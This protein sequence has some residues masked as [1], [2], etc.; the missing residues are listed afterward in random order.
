MALSAAQM[1]AWEFDPA[2]GNLIISDNAADLFG[3]LP[4]S[5]LDHSNQGFALVHPDDAQRHRAVVMKAVDECGSYLSQFRII[6]PD[7][8]AIIWME[9]RG[10]GVG[11]GPGK[12]TR[13]V[14][15]VMDITSRTNA[16]LR[17]RQLQE[18]LEIAIDA[19]ELGTFHC[20]M[21]LG[22]IVWND[23]CKEHFWLEPDAEID[24]DLFYSI[25][26]PDDRER[27]RA[28]VE[29]C[30]SKGKVYDVEYRTVS[31]HRVVRWL[32]ATG[33]TYYDSDQN[34]IRFDGTT[35][36]ITTRKFNERQDQ[37]VFSLDEAIR[38]LS[39]A[40]T[41]TAT[42]ARML[43][44]NLAVDRCAYAEVLADQN[45][46]DV[47]GDFN[48]G[49]PSIVGRYT[50]D[51]LGA[52][53][54]RLMRANLP[55]IVHDID[56]HQPPLEDLSAYRQTQIQ[57]VVCIPLH[58][59]GKLVAAM[60]VHQKTPRNWTP[61]DV[62]LVELV[63][64]RCWESIE[65]ARFA[66]SLHDS[67]AKFR[68]LAN[69]IPQLAWMA[70]PDG[71]IFWYNERWYEYT[72]TTLEQ[73]QGWG[74]EDVHDPVELKRVSV[75]WKA[76]LAGGQP[77]EDEFPLRRH[78]GEFRWHLSRALPLRD[79]EGRI[80][81][82]FGTNT[83]ITDQRRLAEERG[84]LLENE[85]AAR[86]EAEHVGRMKDEFLATLSHELRTPLN[87]ILGYATLM[88]MAKM[89]ETEIQNAIATIERNA[90]L[91]AQLIEDLLDMNRIISGKVRLEIQSVNLA[92]IV[93][94]SVDTVRPSAEAR[95]IRLQ[96][97][98]DP[99]AGPIR[100]DPGR[101][102]QVVWNLLTNAI[103]FTPKGGKVQVV[104]ERVNSHI[105]IT[106]SDSGQG[107]SAEFLPY[108]FD[109]FRQADASTSRRHGGL[110]LGLSIV[111][112]LVEL[113]GGSVQA[114]SPGEGLGSTFIVSLPVTVVHQPLDPVARQH[115]TTPRFKPYECNV[116]LSG[117][118]VLVVDDEP[119]ATALVER[120]LTECKALVTKAGSSREAILILL[121]QE[122]DVL[123][124]D[125]G[126]PVE[127][128]Y[129]LIQKVRELTNKNKDI[130]AVALTAFARSED[131]QR[132]ALVGFQT[133]LAKPVEAAE[134]VAVV[135]N[136]S[137]RHP[138]GK[139]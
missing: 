102:Q 129:L 88:R 59:H 51:Q 57:A 18:Q 136:L 63:A 100:G 34:P 2:T 64:N 97:I 11:S 8:G 61:R 15:V 68:Q 55:Y 77:W 19:S 116:D 103:K 53:A 95:E 13:L 126:M 48:C 90:R 139:T 132:A 123:I 99:V 124:S 86:A 67:E 5:T 137:K 47:T 29:A 121:Q 91:Q 14:G 58:K 66:R 52:E 65:R 21:P 89:S 131:R 82:W 93:E 27:V 125:I 135:A 83:D 130:A 96:K 32:R 7:N 81:L 54:L 112:H 33:R 39:D 28:A 10:H 70:N 109:R 85:R 49:V 60:A 118:R 22:R 72:G 84:L 6:R 119:D 1:A 75:T 78:D 134:L 4:G 105:E 56:S 133:H 110:G 20:E 40:A 69:T 117:I 79:G 41:I 113:H 16:E 111:R 46:F 128:G 115:P 106:I 25:L 74:W 98:I 44:E 101:L 23:R 37:L 104:T 38:P 120:V 17:A 94:A 62:N 87:S 31:P 12:T 108:V 92:E 114:H 3:L 9:E 127:D 73:M 35:Q 80:V 36:D 45:T 138:V 122:F 43:G 76:A 26:H 107:I 71:W 42:T 50:F 30:V 24:F